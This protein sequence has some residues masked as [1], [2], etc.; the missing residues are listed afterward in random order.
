MRL[1]Q[2]CVMYTFIGIQI[3]SDYLR[4]LK[5]KTAPCLEWTLHN[6]PRPHYFANYCL[7]S[8]LR[9]PDNP[10]DYL[11]PSRKSGV[12]R[13]WR[14]HIPAQDVYGTSYKLLNVFLIFMDTIMTLLVIH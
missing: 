1:F 8:C 9:A 13:E 14:N 6:P 11:T 12:Y 4:I 5:Y 3:F 10:N 2:Y 7:T